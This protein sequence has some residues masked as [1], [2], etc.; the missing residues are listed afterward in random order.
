V[1]V[2]GAGE[3]ARQAVGTNC[4]ERAFGCATVGAL[5]T[6]AQYGNPLSR[7]F[8]VALWLVGLAAVIL[9][10]RRDARAYAY[11]KAACTSAYDRVPSGQR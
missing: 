10:W 3:Q 6:F 9:L 11:S 8:S 1:V 5:A 7:I 2:D 4:V